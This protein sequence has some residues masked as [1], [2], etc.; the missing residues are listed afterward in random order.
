MY[1]DCSRQSECD[2]Q[3]AV[4]GLFF[5]LPFWRVLVLETFAVV[6]VSLGSGRF[7]PGN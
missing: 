3:G 2:G 5:E 4:G 7:E 1:V 6:L